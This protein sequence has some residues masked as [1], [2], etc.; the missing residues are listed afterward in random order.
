MEASH[1]CAG[2][3]SFP[4]RCTPPPRAA[5][6]Q[7]LLREYLVR[8]AWFLRLCARISGFLALMVLVEFVAFLLY[9]EYGV[10]R[11]FG[12]PISF[13][14]VALAGYDTVR[15]LPLIWGALVGAL[16]AGATNLISWPVGSYVLSGVFAYPDEADPLI[17]G[18]SL[19]L[20][21]VVGA[22]VGA[23]AGVAARNRRRLRSRRSALDK[24]AYTAFD[25]PVDGR[26]RTKTPVSRAM[27]DRDDRR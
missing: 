5:A 20:A 23:M 10:N 17:V 4:P 22:I 19:L 3:S 11:L 2:L 16:V 8:M 9:R 13:S 12:V 26:D 24:L 6:C 14:L 1:R 15:R 7:I 18:T 25:E 21:A 27:P